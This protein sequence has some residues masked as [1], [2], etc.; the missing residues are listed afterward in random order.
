MVLCFGSESA[1]SSM[2]AFDL[3]LESWTDLHLTAPAPPHMGSLV[4]TY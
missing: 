2:V 4:G 1:D 3:E